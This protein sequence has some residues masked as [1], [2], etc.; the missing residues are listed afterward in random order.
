MDHMVMKLHG[1]LPAYPEYDSLFSG[2]PM[3]ATETLAG[4]G[5]D[6]RTWSPRTAS[7]C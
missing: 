5:V 4:M 2:D 1:S 3:W 7:V 6:G